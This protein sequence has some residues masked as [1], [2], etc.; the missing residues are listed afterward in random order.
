MLNQNAPTRWQ[1]RVNY[2][3]YW[4]KNQLLADRDFVGAYI[5]RNF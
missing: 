5:T 1:G 4:G 3:T 2:T